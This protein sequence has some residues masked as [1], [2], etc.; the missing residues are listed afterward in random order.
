M[1][2]RI[3]KALSSKL[4]PEKMDGVYDEYQSDKHSTVKYDLPSESSQLFTTYVSQMK[5]YMK[6]AMIPFLVVMLA[7]MP[8]IM[9]TGVLDNVLI[10]G[11]MERL[12]YT[13]ESYTAICLALLP[14]MIAFI[15]CI[16]CG[17]T[18]PSEFRF[19]T[20]Y[21]NLSMPQSRLTFYFGKYLAG[22]TLMIA[23][24]L[25]AFGLAVILSIAAGYGSPSAVAT[26]HA[27]LISLAGAMSISGIVYGVSAY[28]AKGSSMLPFVVVFIL[29]PVAGLVLFN[30]IGAASLLGY[31]PGFSGNLA[32]SYLGSD[33]AVSITMFFTSITVSFNAN[34]WLASGINVLCGVVLL[35]LGYDK[36]MNREV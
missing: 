26:G 19:R 32:L 3:F 12:G 28:S 34:V 16:L 20:A 27:L 6:G 5:L 10:N 15:P 21:L 25:L 4:M 14:V 33:V 24:I 36:I 29:I 1:I 23:T 11:F 35:Y 31:I 17:S 22:F 9:L 13:A 7:A 2:G 18:L 8:I 30:G